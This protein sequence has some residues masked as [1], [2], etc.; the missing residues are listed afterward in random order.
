MP[1]PPPGGDSAPSHLVVSQAHVGTVTPI[2]PRPPFSHS[3]LPARPMPLPEQ[4]KTL[5]RHVPRVHDVQGR[6]Q[7]SEKQN[8]TDEPC[9]MSPPGPQSWIRRAPDCLAAA[10]GPGASIGIPRATRASPSPF[11][12]MRRPRPVPSVGLPRSLPG[13]TPDLLAMRPEGGSRAST[14]TDMHP[15]RAA[16]RVKEGRGERAETE[17]TVIGSF[18]GGRLLGEAKYSKVS[19][20]WRNVKRLGNRRADGECQREEPP[21]GGKSEEEK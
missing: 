4:D 3:E 17:R 19:R 6:N 10:N 14:V 20:P 9:E 15:A 18:H 1:P 12:Y 5:A 2:G 7:V 16:G 11:S 21:R 8:A 13:R